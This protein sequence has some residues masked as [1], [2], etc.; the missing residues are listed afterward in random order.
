MKEEINDKGRSQKDLKGEI[1][2]LFV[3]SFST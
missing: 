1:L 3:T 2:E